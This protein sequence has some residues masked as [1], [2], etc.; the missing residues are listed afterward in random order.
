[1]RNMASDALLSCPAEI[2][3]LILASCDTVSE[4]LNLALTCKEL[5]AAWKLNAGN[6]LENLGTRC[7]PAFDEALVAVGDSFWSLSYLLLALPPFIV[8]C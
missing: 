6:I 7:V 3:T 8:P 1:M 5:Y 4:V 2:L